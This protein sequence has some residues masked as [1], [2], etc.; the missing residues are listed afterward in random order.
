[1]LASRECINPDSLDVQ[2]PWQTHLEIARQ[3]II[4]RGG[5]NDK[6]GGGDPFVN[7][8]TR[9]FAYLDV[10][11]SLSGHRN[12]VPLDDMY[13]TFDH[14]GNSDAYGFTIDCF[15]GFTN[16]CISLLARVARLAHKCDSQRI[17]D[18]GNADPDWKPTEEVV[19]EA[20][21]LKKKLSHSRHHVQHG[22]RHNASEDEQSSEKTRLE[23]QEMVSV[24]EAFHLAGLIHVDRR[25]LGKPSSDAEIQDAVKLVLQA[26]KNVRRGGTAESSLL[27]PMF[28]AGC[29]ALD[30]ED[31]EMIL[32][33]LKL[34]EGL[35]MTN[36]SRPMK[37]TSGERDKKLMERPGT[38]CTTTYGKI[39]GD[40][41]AMGMSGYWRVSGISW[42][43]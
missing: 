38:K 11:G 5:L 40:R 1:M 36:V 27:F 42:Q 13:M 6:G 9:W 25:V 15:F 23:L 16:C 26:L 17:D 29:D 21:A 30:V 22:C 4:S 43:E 14:E 32:D 34:V 39:L 28:T 3:I 7:F 31:R 20:G 19:E 24:N 8:L 18:H 37:E 12:Q 33:R 41:Q 2:I 10:I 35:G